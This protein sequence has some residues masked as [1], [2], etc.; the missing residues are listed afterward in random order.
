VR[1]LALAAALA[2]AAAQAD[3][4]RVPAQAQVV[5]AST[6]PGVVEPALAPMQAKLG[7]RVKYLTLRS[8]SSTRLELSQAR[9]SVGLP[10]QKTAELTLVRVKDNVAQV[11]VR[12]PPLDATYSLGK[13][14]SLYVQA[15]PH[16]G[17]DLWLV[18]SQPR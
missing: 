16:D 5:F 1:A 9:S 15:G 4:E 13:D 10:N 2:A 12:L 6:R 14:K 17:G 18:V 8:L 3:G 11:Q 7:A